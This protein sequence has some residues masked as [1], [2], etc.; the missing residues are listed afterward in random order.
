MIE[1]ERVHQVEWGE[2]DP[3]NIVYYP[4]FYS[5]FNQSSHQLMKHIGFGQA[6]MIERYGIV[7]FPLLKAQAE[8]KLPVYWDTLVTI[9]SRISAR[10]NKTFTVNHEIHEGHRTCVVG[11]EIR[12]W[13]IRNE[14]T[15]GHLKAYILPDEFI[16]KIDL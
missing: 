1:Y 15:S 16:Q 2:C 8:F 13:G 7:G 9:K 11:Y 6:E 4:N 14:Q 5:W 3:A 10:S 12:I